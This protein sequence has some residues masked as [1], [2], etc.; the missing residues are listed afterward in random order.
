MEL[1]QARKIVEDAINV[2]LLKGVYGLAD[3][4]VILMALDKINSMQDVEFGELEET[5]K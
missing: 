4:R 5:K 2:A 3:S 1:N